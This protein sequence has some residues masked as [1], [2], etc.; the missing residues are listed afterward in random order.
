MTHDEFNTLRSAF[1]ITQDDQE[2]EEYY[3]TAQNIASKVLEDLE[4]FLFKESIEKAKRYETYLV[5]KA[6]FDPKVTP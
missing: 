5:L 2:E 4:N 1:L 3:D 6:E